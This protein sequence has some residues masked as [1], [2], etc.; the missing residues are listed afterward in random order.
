MLSLQD[1]SIFVAVYGVGMVLEILERSL[2]SEK[3]IKAIKATH[4]IS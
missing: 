4:N 1:E 3:H 2:L